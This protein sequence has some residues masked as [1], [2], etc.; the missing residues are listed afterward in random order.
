MAEQNLNSLDRFRKRSPR[1]L[2]EEHAGCEVPCGCGGVVMRWRNPLEARPVRIHLYT[3]AE[4]VVSID[5]EVVSAGRLDLRPGRHVLAIEIGKVDRTAGLLMAV[6][7]HDP[8]EKPREGALPLV[9]ETPLS[10]LSAADDS[11]R[12]SLQKPAKNWQSLDFDD[13]GWQALVGRDIPEVG[14]SEPKG[15]Q[16]QVCHREKAAG[17][18]V[19]HPGKGVSRHGRVWVRKVFTLESPPTS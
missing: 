3:A 19:P 7:Q 13:S 12:F 18:G 17:L 5:G 1:L 15:Y 9:L 10:I 4:P 6:L 8:R 16:W 14:W 11:W 2:L